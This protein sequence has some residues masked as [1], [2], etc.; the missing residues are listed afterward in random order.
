[1]FEK[2]NTTYDDI[3]MNK[4]ELCGQFNMQRKSEAILTTCFQRLLIN[5]SIFSLLF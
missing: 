3:S 2:A 4:R 1:V 5:E